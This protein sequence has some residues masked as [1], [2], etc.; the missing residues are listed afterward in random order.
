M[1]CSRTSN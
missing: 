1:H